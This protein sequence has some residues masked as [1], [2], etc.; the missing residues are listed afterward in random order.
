[1]AFSAYRNWKKEQT[2]THIIINENGD[3]QQTEC[4]MYVKHAETSLARRGLLKS[5]G[6]DGKN[7]EEFV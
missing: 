7:R 3:P 2:Y 4:T 1:M 5:P 6:Y